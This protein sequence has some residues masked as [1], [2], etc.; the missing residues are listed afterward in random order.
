MSQTL[1]LGLSS[2][3][4]QSYS[5]P[6]R[7]HI[8]RQADKKD[9]ERYAAT[10]EVQKGSCWGAELLFHAIQAPPGNGLVD[11]HSVLLYRKSYSGLAHRIVMLQL[12]FAW[13][14]LGEVAL[15]TDAVSR[16]SLGEQRPIQLTT[17]GYLSAVRACIR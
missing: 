11:P 5:L 8:L 16:R 4:D 13:C 10:L 15:N 14:T 12:P 1:R 3:L 17:E 7:C 6:S 2:D 9:D